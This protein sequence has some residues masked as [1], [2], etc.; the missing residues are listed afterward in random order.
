MGRIAIIDSAN[1]SL[2]ISGDNIA[3]L[4][5]ANV[6]SI[7]VSGGEAPQTE[8]R[9]TDGVA[10]RTGDPGPPNMTVELPSFLPHMAFGTLLKNRQN[11][12]DDLFIRLTMADKIIFD[13]GDTSTFTVA[14]ASNGVVTF[15]GATKPKTSAGSRLIAPGHIIDISGQDSKYVIDSITDIGVVTVNPAPADAISASDTYDILAPSLRN[16]PVIG[17]VRS[18]PA[19]NFTVSADGVLSGTVEF[20]LNNPLPGWEIV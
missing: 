13:S 14:I 12:N 16:G 18:G 11:S 3:W 2:E 4:R 17:K 8:V 19:N 15:A 20:G 1:M 5:V 6:G 7:G 10:Q 9:S